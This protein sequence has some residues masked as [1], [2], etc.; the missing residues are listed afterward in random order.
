MAYAIKGDYSIKGSDAY[1]RPVRRA[2]ST[3]PEVVQLS[4]PLPNVRLSAIGELAQLGQEWIIPHLRKALDDSDMSVASAAAK[5]LGKFKNHDAVKALVA[6]AHSKIHA[7]V[8]HAL[9]DIETDGALNALVSLAGEGGAPGVAV[10]AE[11]KRLTSIKSLGAIYTALNNSGGNHK[12]AENYRTII[13]ARLA[14][15][16]TIPMLVRGL[17]KNDTKQMASWLLRQMPKGAAEEI[18]ATLRDR[19]Y[20]DTSLRTAC[21]SELALYEKS[22]TV[23]TALEAAIAKDTSAEVVAAAAATLTNICGA[24]AVSHV[25]TAY[26]RTDSAAA[27]SKLAIAG[28]L[29]R[30]NGIAALP[31]LI[32]FANI[33][34]TENDLVNKQV[35]AVE[36]ISTIDHPS[37]VTGLVPLL[38]STN[39]RLLD[40]AAGAL[41]KSRSPE[42]R[43]ALHKSL[44]SLGTANQVKA[45]AA[46]LVLAT[47]GDPVAYALCL[48]FDKFHLSAD[49]K[50]SRFHEAASLHLSDPS[51]IDSLELLMLLKL[52]QGTFTPASLNNLGAWALGKMDAG[53]IETH[54]LKTA[55]MHRVAATEL[56]I[57]SVRALARLG[58]E[59]FVALK[60]AERREYDPQV[61]SAMKLA[62]WRKGQNPLLRLATAASAFFR[63]PVEVIDPAICLKDLKDCIARGEW[64]LPSID[65][66][67]VVEERLAELQGMI[68]LRRG[69]P[70]MLVETPA[71][72]AKKST[73]TRIKRG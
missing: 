48:L 22:E 30:F 26:K 42:A 6:K 38:N 24:P 59:G 73:K 37:A 34:E 29:I 23:Q 54:A 12:A 62:L 43:S 13:D 52:N 20:S 9:A 10:C 8:I 21:A 60:D 27:K 49:K 2:A 53:A 39:R 14:D 28:T 45:E 51:I 40:A 70:E 56:G 58:K 7:D 25:M 32:E 65:G 1:S 3:P 33:P 71:A 72:K 17:V 16:R 19:K 35:E 46:L 44:L 66:S 5:A 57:L 47:A 61:R 4:D 55:L 50:D 67:I 63:P 64:P 36:K 11:L 41:A 18:A 31:F 69:S 15:T 68:S